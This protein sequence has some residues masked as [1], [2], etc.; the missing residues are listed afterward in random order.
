MKYVHT[1]INSAYTLPYI[2][3][4]KLNFKDY[5]HIFYVIRKRSLDKT[6]IE[7]AENIHVIKSFLNVFIV[8]HLV[9]NF[10]RSKK[11]FLHGLFNICLVVIL[12]FQPWLIRKCNWILWGG[13]LHLY[14]IRKSDLKS[15]LK[16]LLRAMVIRQFPKLLTQIKEDYE[17]A[18]NW[19]KA[20][21]VF[22]EVIYPLPLDMENIDRIIGSQLTVPEKKDTL[23]IQIG[24]S[25]SESNNH[26]DIIHALTKFKEENIKI[27]ALLS[28]G[29]ELYSKR[30][31]DYGKSVFAEKFVGTTNFMEYD[32]FVL[33]MNSMDIIIFNH[34]RQQGLGN[35]F[36][37]MYLKKKVFIKRNNALWNYFHIEH[38][39]NTFCTDEIKLMNFNI[40]KAKND[41]YLEEIKEKIKKKLS[42]EY[43]YQL[44]QKQFDK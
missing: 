21:G 35:L 25:A 9:R 8:I 4:I 22:E 33:Y 37:A 7:K 32:D 30:I 3:F 16:F 39:I 28:Y 42:H 36:L 17:L 29:D 13:D 40:F 23:F 11:I 6:T 10:Y 2:R 34:E 1:I 31:I 44:W 18:K 24:N 12:F 15:Y 27:F 43:I 5:E 14:H 41:T 26:I 20:K 19:Y 38:G